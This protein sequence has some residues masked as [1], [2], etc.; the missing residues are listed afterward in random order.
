MLNGEEERSEKRSLLHTQRW[1]VFLWGYILLGTFI[2]RGCDTRLDSSFAQTQESIRFKYQRAPHYLSFL[3]PSLSFCPRPFHF[4]ILQPTPEGAPP[5]LHLTFNALL[6]SVSHANLLPLNTKLCTR[7]WKFS[8]SI[9]NFTS[10]L[11]LIFSFG[12]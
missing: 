2:W 7:G 11:I 1:R 12:D 4:S 5:K 6:N 9:A 10:I 3:H 8:K